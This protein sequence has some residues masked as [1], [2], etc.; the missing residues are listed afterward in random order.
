MVVGEGPHCRGPQPVKCCM[1]ISEPLFCSKRGF[2]WGCLGVFFEIEAK[3]KKQQQ[4][5]RAAAAAAAA[6]SV[7]ALSAQKQHCQC[8]NSVQAPLIPT[9]RITLPQHQHIP[10]S[11]PC[12]P[13]PPSCQLTPHPL[14][15]SSPLAHSTHTRAQQHC[16]PS[17]PASSALTSGAQRGPPPR[18]R[19]PWCR[20][21]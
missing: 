1:P 8:S 2:Y 10:S 3:T 18:G 4:Q 21:V 14:P 19:S 12:P 9:T 11:P 7:T 16:P 13:L 17:I 15:S 6:Q 20:C 5:Q